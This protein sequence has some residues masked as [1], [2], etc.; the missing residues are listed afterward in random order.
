MSRLVP[1]DLEKSDGERLGDLSR[2]KVVGDLHSPLL[3]TEDKIGGCPNT[4]IV[5]T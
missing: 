2:V 1:L 3:W 5:L 4:R